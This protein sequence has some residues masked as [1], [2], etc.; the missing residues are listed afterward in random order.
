MCSLIVWQCAWL[1]C[2]FKQP[3]TSFIQR[4]TRTRNPIIVD[5]IAPCMAVQFWPWNRGF[6]HCHVVVNDVMCYKICWN[7]LSL[8]LADEQY[9]ADDWPHRKI[10]VLIDIY[11]QHSDE[12]NHRGQFVSSKSTKKNVWM[13]IASSMQSMG[14]TSVT[15]EK[16]EKK[17]R[18]LSGTYRSI[19]DNNR[20]NARCGRKKW[21]YYEKFQ[22]CITTA[23]A[24]YFFIIN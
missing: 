11:C 19:V 7:I 3:I 23:L 8:F 22:V 4:V 24:T 18:N 1:T 21:P 15:W 2:Q 6:A 12:M 16:C 17:F 5:M 14:Y 13:K 9:R 10:L 20:Q